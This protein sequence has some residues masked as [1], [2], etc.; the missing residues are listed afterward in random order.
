MHTTFYLQNL[1]GRN[2]LQ[3]LGAHG[4]ITLKWIFTDIDYDYV[5]RKYLVQSRDRTGLL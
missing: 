2:H 5:D 1:E 4:K 3:E